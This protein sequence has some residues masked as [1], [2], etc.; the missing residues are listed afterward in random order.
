MT[1]N[2][3]IALDPGNVL[4]GY[5]VCQHDGNDIVK[6]IDKGK[7]ANAKIF[8]ILSAYKDYD[9]V[10]EIIEPRGMPIGHETIDTIKA[11]GKF[12]QYVEDRGLA[13]SAA[14]IKRREEQ[15]NI[16]GTTRSNDAT[17][18]HA[19][20]ERYAPGVPNY[21][22]GSKKEPGFFFG[23]AADA[24]MAFAVAVT[25]ADRELKGVQIL[26]KSKKC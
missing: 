10:I 1:E 7:L 21:G 13:R 3:L 24:W 4:T 5:V 2:I 19:L 11:I 12:E 15:I 23:M 26:A 18:R 16:C 9:F 8:D 22:K 25:W 20:A 17:I 6:I 14:E